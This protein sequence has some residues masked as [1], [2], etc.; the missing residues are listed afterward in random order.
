MLMNFGPINQRGGEKRLNVIFSR[1]RMHMAV[2]SSIRHFDIKNEYNDG[3]NCL[4]HFLEYAAACS[5]GDAVTARRVL[6]SSN[7]LLGASSP[8]DDG[9]RETVTAQL[10]DALRERGLRVDT[11]V[12]QSTFRLPLAV[13]RL[14]ETAHALGILIDD[15]AHYAQKDLL[16]RYLL[17]PGVLNAF[18][19]QVVTVFTKD[20]YQDPEAV[21]RRIEDAL[22]GVAPPVVEEPAVEMKHDSNEVGV[23]S[24]VRDEAGGEISAPSA[25]ANV[26]AK[27]P[28]EEKIMT[29]IALGATPAARRENARSVVQEPAEI[30][31][32]PSVAGGS[33]SVRHFTSHEG[34]ASKFWE[35]V[36]NGSELTVRF[37]RIGTRGQV[38]T[39]MF[40]TPDAARR[41]QEKLIRSKIAKG[42]VEQR[43]EN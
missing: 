21:C 19:W 16:E 2:V 31:D 42:Y 33:G 17:R 38:Q 23:E 32:A 11:Q 10:A 30:P 43:I 8:R 1:A 25:P 6:Q 34:G 35:A 24:V 13:R 22:E 40:A 7:G 3:A 18:G 12:G 14:N 28:I 41:E 4:R 39:K 20:W 27:S 37:G 15:A 5:T 29:P 36:L 9:P 26:A